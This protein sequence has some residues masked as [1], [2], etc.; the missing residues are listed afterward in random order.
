MEKII[1]LLVF[2][3]SSFFIAAQSSGGL[4]LK[5]KEK[6]NLHPIEGLAIEV[7]QDTLCWEL[8]TDSSGSIR[9]NDLNFGIVKINFHFK[10]HL[11][12]QDV[13]IQE[14]QLLQYTVL[15]DST[16]LN[17]QHLISGKHEESAHG[18]EKKNQISDGSQYPMLNL[19]KANG[20][21]QEFAEI[22]IRAYKS[23]LIM[24]D[25]GANAQM[26]TREDISRMPIRS[27][28]KVASI[29][30]GVNLNESNGELNILGARGEANYYF[31]DGVKVRGSSNLPKSY[32]G[33]VTVY[34]G[35]IPANYGDVTGGV[36]SIESRAIDMSALPMSSNTNQSSN[37]SI[38]GASDQ[39]SRFERMNYDRFLPIYENNFLSPMDHPH[40]TFGIDVDQ[41]AWNYVKRR[42]S[43]GASIQR[44]AVKLEEMVNAFSYD[45]LVVPENEWVEVNMTRS[46]CKWNEAHELVTVHLR[47]RDYSSTQK[48]KP[49]NFVFLVDVSGSMSSN[50]KLPLVINGLKDLVKEM[51]S[52]D[53]ISIVTYAGNSSVPLPSTSCEDK[54]KIFAALDNLYAGGGTNGMGGVQEAY[55]QAELN[56][57]TTYNNRIILATDGDFN[58]GIS[59]TGGLEKYISTKRGQGI[60]LTA[61]GFGMGNYKNSTL[62]TLAKRGD[63]NHFY[64]HSREEMKSVFADPGNLTNAIRDVKLDV[65]FNPRLISSYRLIGYE[66]RLLKP[67]DFDDD[68]KDGGELGYGHN[69]TAVFEV[70]KGKSEAVES[71]FQKSIA[72]F[73]RQELAYIKL[74]YKPLEAKESVER[75]YSL[76]EDQVIDSNPL[77]N[78]VIGLGLELRDSAFKGNLTKELLLEMV[79]DIKASSKEEKELIQIVKAL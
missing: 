15:L 14:K 77:L 43:I 64:I 39:D 26:I 79:S 9:L 69:V 65:E 68:T 50:N 37:S 47:V 17:V 36:I 41:A 75:R 11:E 51:S 35:S 66:S 72:K 27:A 5:C 55:R 44:D 1:G 53:R 28:H 34:N 20:A 58:I 3:L 2:V 67:Q 60:Y 63:G 54:S 31:I 30:S 57:D 22:Q 16:K 70:E 29:V 38:S 23:P 8:K 59:N 4:L 12:E 62:E 24:K 78:L 18:Q 42:I 46:N 56:Y 71:H 25:G 6:S 10:D 40:A 74:R 76:P 61:L 7:F 45:D 73:S 19:Q 13:F 52:Q 48:R 21:T 49:H 32:I 33:N